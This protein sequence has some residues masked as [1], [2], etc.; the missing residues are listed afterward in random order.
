MFAKV[1]RCY[2][3]NLLFFQMLVPRKVAFKQSNAMCR[4]FCEEFCN[5]MP[6]AEF[7]CEELQVVF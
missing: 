6:P 2:V 3:A 7:V 4:N 5:L 1:C